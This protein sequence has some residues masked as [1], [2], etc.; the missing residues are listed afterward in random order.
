MLDIHD[1]FCKTV[2]KSALKAQN[3]NS[4]KIYS[5][6]GKAFSIFVL[7]ETMRAFP[8]LLYTVLF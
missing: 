6:S 7:N 4:K 3:C 5:F 1:R 8:R 2:T